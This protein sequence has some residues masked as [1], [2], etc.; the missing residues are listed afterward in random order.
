MSSGETHSGCRVMGECRG[1]Q[2]RRRGDQQTRW[3]T[4]GFRSNLGEF[5]RYR[6]LESLVFEFGGRQAEFLHT[7]ISGLTILVPF[8]M[9]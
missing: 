4:M 3:E 9:K 8:V 5:K 1:C 7:W 6:E 2:S